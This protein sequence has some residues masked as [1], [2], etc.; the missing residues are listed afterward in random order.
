MSCTACIRLVPAYV[1]RSF[2]TVPYSRDLADAMVQRRRETR[3]RVAVL[4]RAASSSTGWP[5]ETLASHGG[6]FLPNNAI[7]L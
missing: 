5:R 4:F 1:L 6:G 3:E 7:V 2:S